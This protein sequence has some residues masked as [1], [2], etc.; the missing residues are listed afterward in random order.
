[1]VSN[2]FTT[3]VLWFSHTLSMG[4]GAFV[5][6]GEYTPTCLI[7][8]YKGFVYVK[9]MLYLCSVM[10]HY[11]LVRVAPTLK[12]NRKFVKKLNERMSRDEMTIQ[13]SYYK[14]VGTPK[15]GFNTKND[16]VEI[17]I[18]FKIKEGHIMY[19]NRETFTQI[20]KGHRDSRKIGSRIKSIV[21]DHIYDKYLKHL[22]AYRW[23]CNV[24]MSWE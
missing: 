11:S 4:V 16:L 23:E 2:I 5:V 9:D 21:Q 3:F 1:V 8:F 6:T 20:S 10:N 19:Y 12:E 15:I 14:V 17:K 13:T 18:T 24:S 22:G 7:F